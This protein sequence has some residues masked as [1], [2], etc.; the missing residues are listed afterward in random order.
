M[1]VAKTDNKD[2]YM[3]VIASRNQM[4]PFIQSR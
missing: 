1:Q 4:A 3:G 2:V